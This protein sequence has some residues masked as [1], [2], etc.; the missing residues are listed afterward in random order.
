MVER[1][2]EV[3]ICT[4]PISCSGRVFLFWKWTNGDGKSTVIGK[5]HHVDEYMFWYKPGYRLGYRE[6]HSLILY[7]TADHHNTNITCEAE[8][9][10]DNA[11]T[12]VTLTVKCKEQQSSS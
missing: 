12:S 10:H 8:Y 5:G 4:A 3:L 7:P 1:Q 9:K 6:R 2:R 11:E